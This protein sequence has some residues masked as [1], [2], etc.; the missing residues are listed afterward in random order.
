MQKER[1]LPE[2]LQFGIHIYEAYGGWIVDFMTTDGQPL[3]DYKKKLTPS[4]WRKARKYLT[5]RLIDFV[6][7]QYTPLKLHEKEALHIIK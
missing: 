5:R 2:Y 4:Q 6:G 7:Y 3:P 1:K